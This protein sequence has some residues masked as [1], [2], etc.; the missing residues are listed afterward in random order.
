MKSILLALIGL[1]VVAA[2]ALAELTHVDD[3]YGS[4]PAKSAREM[5]HQL[6]KFQDETGITIIMRLHPQSPSEAEDH[7]P[8]ASMRA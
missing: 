1:C 2:P 6:G 8:G 5:D 7:A 4:I 3:I